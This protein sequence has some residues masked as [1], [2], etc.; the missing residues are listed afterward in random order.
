MNNVQIEFISKPEC[1]LCDDAR[2]IV[3][4]VLTEFSADQVVLSERSIL[5]DAELYDRFWEEIPVV[6]INGKVHDFWRV[7]PERFRAAVTAALTATD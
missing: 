7:D 3:Q 6:R 4:S 2:E 1:H 5:D